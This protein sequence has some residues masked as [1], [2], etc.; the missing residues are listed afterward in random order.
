MSA[1]LQVLQSEHRPDHIKTDS[2]YTLRGC[3]VHRFA[4]F[5]NGWRKVLHADLWK[6]LHEILQIRG[7]SVTMSKVKGHATDECAKRGGLFSR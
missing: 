5:A 7:D 1:V 6:Q 3:L 4:W 2:A